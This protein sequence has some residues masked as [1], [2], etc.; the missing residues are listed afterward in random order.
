MP[1]DPSQPICALS[2]ERFDSFWD[3][4]S[5]GW[6]YKGATALDAEQAARY[7]SA[8]IAPQHL[9]ID[10]TC[11]MLIVIQ[12]NHLYLILRVF[13]DMHR[14][15]AP[16]FPGLKQMVISPSKNSIY[17]QICY[18]MLHVVED[19]DPMCEMHLCWQSQIHGI[20]AAGMV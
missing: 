11:Y 6:R 15:A 13:P 5:N 20:C 17:S 7:R 16:Q 12:G 3:D 10:S 8:L 18:S 9:T 1:A 14:W 2:G 19:F 4:A